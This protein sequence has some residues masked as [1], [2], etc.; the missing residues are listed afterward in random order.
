[1]L[2]HYILWDFYNNWFTKDDFIEQNET[3]CYFVIGLQIYIW[4]V[5]FKG[6]VGILHE[7][8]AASKVILFFLCS[9][10]F[11]VSWVH[12]EGLA[13]GGSHQN[14]HELPQNVPQRGRRW[15]VGGGQNSR[16]NP[17]LT[18]FIQTCGLQNTSMMR[19]FGLCFEFV[20]A[21]LSKWL[22]W[23]KS[24]GIYIILWLMWCYILC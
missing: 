13:S 1:M 18:Y 17:Y 8:T 3:V 10:L 19:G 15:H 12:N 24:S 6:N 22:K 4:H 21:R 14:L 7:I 5:C 16:R 23:V 11:V 9:F 20:L 2:N